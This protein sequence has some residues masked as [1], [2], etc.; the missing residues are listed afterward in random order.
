MI[1][2][3]DLDGR[4]IQCSISEATLDECFAGEASGHFAAFRDNFAQIESA[5]HKK[6]QAVEHPPE[7]LVLT[8]EDFANEDDSLHWLKG[9]S[10]R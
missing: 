10:D 7:T 4:R 8:P 6:G 2:Y 9:A 5:A 3:T 1:F